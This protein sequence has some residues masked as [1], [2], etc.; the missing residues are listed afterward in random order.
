MLSS[1]KTLSEPEDVAHHQPKTSVLNLP[2]YLQPGA[3][4]ISV[5]RIDWSIATREMILFLDK[6]KRHIVL[7]TVTKNF[8]S[9]TVNSVT[10]NNR[11][12]GKKNIFYTFFSVKQGE[13]WPTCCPSLG[14]LWWRFGPGCSGLSQH[15]PLH[16]FP[17]P[18]P[19]CRL[20]RWC[21]THTGTHT[22]THT[23]IPHIIHHHLKQVR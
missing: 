5:Y 6:I 11:K 17:A 12:Y 10:L 16:T 14:F 22:N 13:L 21:R 8:E 19:P 2:S 23:Y 18:T 15:T 9:W 7:K 20:S 4:F 3:V 1:L